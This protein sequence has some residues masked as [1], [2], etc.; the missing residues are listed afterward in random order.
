MQI[1]SYDKKNTFLQAATNEPTNQS[2]QESIFSPTQEKLK[3]K[4]SPTLQKIKLHST[5]PCKI[6]PTS[7]LM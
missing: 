7:P 6:Q 2:L 4:K 3:N 5:A 1:L